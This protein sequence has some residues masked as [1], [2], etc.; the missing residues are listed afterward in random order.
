MLELEEECVVGAGRGA[1]GGLI[2]MVPPECLFQA[3]PERKHWRGV[4]LT[5][6]VFTWLKAVRSSRSMWVWLTG[7]WLQL[8]SP[9]LVPTP[10]SKIRQYSSAE[11]VMMEPCLLQDCLVAL[12]LQEQAPKV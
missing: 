11:P 12:V 10:A 8:N 9:L 1:G 5:K 2:L 4:I 3:I 7:K 6:K